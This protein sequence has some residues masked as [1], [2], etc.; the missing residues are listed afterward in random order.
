[1]AGLAVAADDRVRPGA[2][3]QICTAGRDRMGHVGLGRQRPSPPVRLVLLLRVLPACGVLTGLAA[4]G[5]GAAGGT[6][7]APVAGREMWAATPP[8]AGVDG[9]GAGAWPAPAA[10]PARAAWRPAPRR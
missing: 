6:D 5:A 3:D 8:A 1:L 2:A 9:R 4:R 7:P 10:G